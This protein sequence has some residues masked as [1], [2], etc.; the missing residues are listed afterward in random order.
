MLLEDSEL[1]EETDL[2]VRLEVLLV[3]GNWLL[4]ELLDD[5]VTD[6]E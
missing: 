6:D 1:F 4:E 5:E 2:D 3:D